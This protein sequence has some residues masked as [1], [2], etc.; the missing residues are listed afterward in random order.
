MRALTC[1]RR[2]L[3]GRDRRAPAWRVTVA[4]KPRLVRTAF[5][6]HYHS[7]QVRIFVAMSRHQAPLHA[8][9]R[10]PSADHRILTDYF[11]HPEH[12]PEIAGRHVKGNTDTI[13]ARTIELDRKLLQRKF[14]TAQPEMTDIL[15]VVRLYI[16]FAAVWRFELPLYQKIRATRIVGILF[17]FELRVGLREYRSFG[18]LVVHPLNACDIWCCRNTETTWHAMA[19]SATPDKRMLV[20][21]PV[22]GGALHG[23]LDFRPCL[24]APP[25]QR[26]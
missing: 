8:I 15:R 20:G 14:D 24:K 11:Y 1:H 25:L 3:R 2:R 6:F 10:Q 18:S 7:G 16:A 19:P 12:S 23:L 21:V 4:G 17:G 9:L 13:V 22:I 5:M 26:Q